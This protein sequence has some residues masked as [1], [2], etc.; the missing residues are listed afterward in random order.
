MKHDNN[1]KF[2][3]KELKIVKF[4]IIPLSLKIKKNILS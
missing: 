4:A 1:S 2:S 3:Q